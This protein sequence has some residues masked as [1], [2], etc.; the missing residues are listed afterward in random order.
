MELVKSNHSIVSMSLIALMAFC[1]ILFTEG[2]PAFI[3]SLFDHTIALIPTEER[4]IICWTPSSLQAGILLHMAFHAISTF[5]LTVIVTRE[6]WILI[7]NKASR[8]VIHAPAVLTFVIT[9]RFLYLLKREWP[10]GKG[11]W[12]FWCFSL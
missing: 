11:W 2:K 8:A 1:T 4:I 6:V 9:R 5:V 12:G 7:F 10:R 3:A